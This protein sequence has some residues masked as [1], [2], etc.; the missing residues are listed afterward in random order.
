LAAVFLSRQEGRLR[1]ENE[2]LRSQIAA[3]QNS[4]PEPRD[5]NGVSPEE[6]IR[7]TRDAADVLRLRG[8]VSAL[9]RDQSDLEKLREENVGLRA[10]LLAATDKE[11]KPEELNPQMATAKQDCCVMARTPPCQIPI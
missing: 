5:S 7:L 4:P 8:E 10:R 11:A 9:R 6:L 3:R 1:T 2:A